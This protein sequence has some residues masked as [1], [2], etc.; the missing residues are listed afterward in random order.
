MVEEKSELFF[1]GGDVT[2]Q[3]FREFRNIRRR[4]DGIVLVNNISNGFDIFVLKGVQK[5]MDVFVVEVESPRPSMAFLDI[6]ATVIS[7]IRLLFNSSKKAA[8]ME[9]S[10]LRN[11]KSFFLSVIV[12]HFL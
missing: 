7:E 9:S 2:E 1:V 11:R 3:F 6:S 5:V 8:R 4:R 12:E 10:V